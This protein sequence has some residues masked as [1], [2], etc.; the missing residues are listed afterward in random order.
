MGTSKNQRRTA[1]ARVTRV[2][3]GQATTDLSLRRLPVLKRKKIRQ[4]RHRLSGKP[5]DKVTQ[6]IRKVGFAVP[7]SPRL[8]QL[9]ES[10]VTKPKKIPLRRTLYSPQMERIKMQI[11][12]LKKKPWAMV[13]DIDGTIADKDAWKARSV[14]LWFPA[15]TFMIKVQETY[16]IYLYTAANADHATKVVEKLRTR[17]NI[18]VL[19]AFHSA[20]CAGN[21]KHSRPFVDSYERV[22]IYDD[23]PTVWGR[24][25]EQLVKVVPSVSINDFYRKQL[26]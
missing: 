1:K 18:Q 2:L 6:K 7:E 10:L 15:V 9:E 14:D 20:F 4:V 11:D 17:H 12:S 23:S 5:K 24:N 19:F 3:S 16:D 13:F 26:V 21:K 22:V 25:W 8:S